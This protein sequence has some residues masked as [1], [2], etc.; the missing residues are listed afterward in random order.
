MKTGLQNTKG[1][2]T[3]IITS[4]CVSSPLSL[5]ISLTIIKWSHEKKKALKFLCIPYIRIILFFFQLVSHLAR[6]RGWVCSFSSF[7]DDYIINQTNDL[8]KSKGLA[9]FLNACFTFVL[10]FLVRDLILSQIRAFLLMGGRN[11]A[12]NHYTDEKQV[13]TVSISFVF[14]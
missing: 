9:L 2:K 13:R 7:V 10:Y 11:P 3:S 8:Q 14:L 1:H 12:G 4:I 5:R 6:K